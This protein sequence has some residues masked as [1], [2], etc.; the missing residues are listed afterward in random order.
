MGIYLPVTWLANPQSAVFY[1]KSSMKGW[2]ATTYHACLI[3]GG[4]VY[5]ILIHID[6]TIV[7]T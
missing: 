2:F 3:T 5:I 6:Y 4:Y 7:H 1:G